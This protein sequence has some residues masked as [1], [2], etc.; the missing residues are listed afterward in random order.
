MLAK[1]ITV[2]AIVLIVAYLVSPH[3]QAAN[4]IGAFGKASASNVRALAGGV[5]DGGGSQAAYKGY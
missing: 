2:V 5:Y 1:W 3:S 4:V